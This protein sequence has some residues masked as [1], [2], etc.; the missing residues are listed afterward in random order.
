MRNYFVY[1]PDNGLC[2]AWRCTAISMG[3][4]VIPPG[5]IYPPRR[6]PDDHHLDWRNGRILQ[7][8]QIVYISAGQGTFEYGPEHTRVAIQTGDIFV[9]FPGVWHR[10]EPDPTMGWTENWIECKSAAYDS[11][12]EKGLLSPDRPVMHSN[13]HI[14]DLF[15][16]IHQLALEGATDNQALLSTQALSLLS[17]LARPRE[18]VSRKYEQIVDA[19]RMYLLEH[20][21]QVLDMD[22][23][24]RHFGIS[25]SYLRRLFREQTG[26]SIKQFQLNIRLQRGCD[27]LINTDKS[28][29]EIASL[30]GFANT[31]HFSKFFSKEKGMSP[32]EWRK[33]R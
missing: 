17:L 25:Y 26:V 32:T 27:F 29:K 23:L 24:A 1:L 18:E 7:A 30:L 6:H 3:H 10:Y 31:F 21:T 13:G 33:R 19:V 15:V 16:R 9:L 11:L 4:T 5:S 12:T 20:H 8:Y 28:I 22:E 2:D 14:S